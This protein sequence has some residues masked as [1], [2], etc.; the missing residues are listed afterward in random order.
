MDRK[1]RQEFWE[2]EVKVSTKEFDFLCN[3]PQKPLFLSK[4]VL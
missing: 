4:I 1:G 3:D 2:C